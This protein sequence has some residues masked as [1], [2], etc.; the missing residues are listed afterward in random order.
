M[1]QDPPAMN[2]G[3]E[4]PAGTPGTGEDVCPRCRGKGQLDGQ[5]PCPDCGGSG[6]IIEGI[7]GG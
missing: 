1:Q 5:Q 6:K 4:A 3:D 2:P 7:G